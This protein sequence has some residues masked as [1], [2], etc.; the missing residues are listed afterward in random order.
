[1]K[2][3]VSGR[4]R[5]PCSQRFT[6][7]RTPEYPDVRVGDSMELMDECAI[8]GMVAGMSGTANEIADQSSGV[9]NAKRRHLLQM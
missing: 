2:E 4:D 9:D 3:N 7:A 5:D 8:L 1:V 6:E